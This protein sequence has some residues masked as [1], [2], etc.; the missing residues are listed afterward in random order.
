VGVAALAWFLPS[1]SLS[2]GLTAY[3]ASLGGQASRV[4]ELSP[5][6]GSDALVRNTLLTVY[7]LFWGLL[8]FALLLAAGIVAWLTAR[9]RLSEETMFFALWLVP[10]AF[11]YVTIHIGDPGYLMSVLPGLYVACAALL[12]PIARRAAPI[13]LPWTALFVAINAAV[14]ALGDGPFSASAIATHDRVTGQRAAAVRAMAPS[15]TVVLARSDYLI[16]RYYLPGYTVLF[17]G[18]APEVLSSAVREMRVTS[19]TAVF[20]FGSLPSPLPAAVRLETERSGTIVPG[21]TLVAY[22][23]EPR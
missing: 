4:S 20:Y 11:V 7:A 22:D 6:A 23:L 17:D 12:A 14:F 21:A 19:P 10:A 8:G 15:S 18:A 3:L 13:V 2:G 9:R 16:A 5:A 1:A